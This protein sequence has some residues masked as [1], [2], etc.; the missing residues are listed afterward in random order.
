MEWL[1]M[2]LPV[3]QVLYWEA[4]IE[5]WGFVAFGLLF[6]LELARLAFRGKLSWNIVGDSVTNFVTMGLFFLVSFVLIFGIYTSAFYWVY[7]NFALVDIPVTPWSVLLL[8][9]LC[10][11]AYYW[12]HRFLHR[13]GLGWATHTVHHSSPH[14]NISVAYRFGPMDGF[15]PLFFH[16]PLA[17]VGFDP[18]LIFAA[19]AFVQVYQTVLHTEV[20]KKLPRPI[21][22]IMNTPSHH[23]VHHGSNP[24]YIDKNYGGIFIIWDKMFGTFAEERAPVNFGLTE[25]V[26][27]INPFYVFLHG[28]ERLFIRA[29]Q[30]SGVGETAYAFIAPPEWQPRSL[31]Q[32]E[33]LGMS[34][35]TN[36]NETSGGVM[37]F[38]VSTTLAVALLLVGFSYPGYSDASTTPGAQTVETAA[39]PADSTTAP[40]MAGNSED[41]L[42]A[43]ARLY[44]EAYISGKEDQAYS[45]FTEDAQLSYE[46]DFG[47]FYGK[48][49]YSF[50]ANE[51][52]PMDES[53]FAGFE[54]LD[55]SYSIDEINITD[56]GGEVRASY[57]ERYRWDG[58]EGMMTAKE[59]M[60]LEQFGGQLYVV[61]FETVQVYQ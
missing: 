26:R 57:R 44:Y 46:L 17:L 23:R 31:R 11:F 21:E 25:P 8:V 12:E 56:G 35:T 34:V 13:N 2:I 40:V 41:D 36:R 9:V 5:N 32:Q 47:L 55:R 20:I 60:V 14:F 58:Y 29:G 39:S 54:S 1:T 50:R 49:K 15:W 3:E 48:E 28:I 19:E 6:L 4:W 59:L 10:D 51:A 43:R 61:S 16:I 42:R 45:I 33:D 7:L 24:E 22:A 27:S 30:A 37:N 52:P 53:M 38:L 18:L